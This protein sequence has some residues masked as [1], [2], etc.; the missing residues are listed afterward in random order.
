LIGHR[1][2]FL[3]PERNPTVRT[4]LNGA[5]VSDIV[6]DT[7]TTTTDTIDYVAADTDGLT[8]TSTR[9]VLIEPILRSRR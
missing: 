6:L 2:E 5:L 1:L 7:S 8:S 4:F 9:T 3:P